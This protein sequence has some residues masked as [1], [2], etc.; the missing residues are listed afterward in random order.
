MR[1]LYFVLALDTTLLLGADVYRRKNKNFF[2]EITRILEKNEFVFERRPFFCFLTPWLHLINFRKFLS[3]I[4][5]IHQVEQKRETPLC[6]IQSVLILIPANQFSTA[7]PRLKLSA[8]IT[9]VCYKM[10]CINSRCTCLKIALLY[11]AFFKRFFLL[12]IY[13]EIETFNWL[14]ALFSS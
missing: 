12:L 5:G 9:V 10:N 6:R 8:K 2:L 14:K 4:K 1:R 7:L 3:R 11:T 13:A